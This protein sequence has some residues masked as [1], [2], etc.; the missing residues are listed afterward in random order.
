LSETQAKTFT[1]NRFARITSGF[2]ALRVRNFRLF[3]IGQGISLIGTWMQTTAQAWLVIQLTDSPFALGF[4]TTLQFLPVMILSLYG[5]VLA[6]RLPKRRTLIVTQSLLL[7]QAAIFGTLVATGT[8]QLWHVY[9]LAMCQGLVQAIDIPVRQS[10]FVEMVGREELSNAIALNSM[11]FNGARIIGPALAGV[12]IAKIGIAP[13]LI[14]NA[15]SF[16]AV[17]TG[18]IMMRESELHALPKRKREPVMRQLREGLDYAWRTPQ[19][20]VIIIALAALGTFGYNFTVTLPMIANFVLHT[21]ASGYGL[22]SASFGIGALIA[23]IATAYIKRVTVQRMLI[24]G[25]AFSVLL[26]IV[27]FSPIFLLSAAI[28][29]GVGISS[30]IFSTSTNT[31]MQLTTPDE[32]R[33][34]VISLNVLLIGGSTPIGGFL[35]GFM[36]D[37]LGVPFA[38]FACALVCAIGIVVAYVYQ[39]QPAYQNAPDPRAEAALTAN[40]VAGDR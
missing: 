13:A 8:I 3:V 9:I 38:L 31:L 37:R 16:I 23:A 35:T 27:S 11:T 5:G 7:I 34:R 29:A 22:L 2:H 39:R 40:P 14:L 12:L 19:I 10:F 32:L 21:D 20:R 33:G 30:I 36:A 15:L 18:L 28:M 26:G 17:I 25:A 6:D 4:V 24:G 1:S